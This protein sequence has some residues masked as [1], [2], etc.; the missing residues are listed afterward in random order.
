M[1][2]ARN[3]STHPRAFHHVAL[4]PDCHRGFGIPIGCVVAC[5]G[6]LIPNAVGVDI[7]CGMAALRTPLRADDLEGGA[8]SAIIRETAERIPVGEGVSRRNPLPLPPEIALP[9]WLDSRA[10][11]LASANLGTLGGGNHF[12]ELQAGDDGFIWLTIHTG[13]RNLGY[14]IARHHNEIAVR[15][16]SRFGKAPADLAFLPDDSDEGILYVRDME[17]A[18]AYARANRSA[19]MGDFA[20]VFA[21]VTGCRITGEPI[22][23][24]HNYASKETHFGAHVWVHRKGATSAR[25][26]ETGIIP[27]SMGT[28]SWIVRGLGS[29]DS[30]M[31]CS[32]GAGRVLGRREAS[33]KL[34]VEE[35]REAMRGVIYGTSG[36]GGRLRGFGEGADLSEAPAAYRD[37]DKVM[38]NQA[39][40]VAPLVR[41]RPL[42][43]LKG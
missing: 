19:V 40:L 4:M 18:M 13:S 35:C 37:I 34:S 43:V 30:F 12:I 24:H 7:G 3:I 20:E 16:Q 31:S 6:A 10:R 32:H 41:L 29:P 25:E 22:S 17:T 1:E 36:R 5:R 27:G 28:T 42:G 14:R 23:I 8:V 2:Q 15:M 33:R 11:S 38:R 39:D 26:G 21:G 9:S